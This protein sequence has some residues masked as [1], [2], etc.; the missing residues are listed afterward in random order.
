MI[1][2]R[3]AVIVGG[4]G[5]CEAVPILIRRI[6]SEMDASL[7]PAILPPFRAHEDKLRKEAELE[8]YVELA[9]R[10]LDGKGGILI[11]IDC[12]WNDS[13]PK[14]DGPALL[15]RARACR[16]DMKVTVVL[17]HR[18]FEAWFIA[19]SRSISGKRGLRADL[20]IIDDP[21]RVRGAKEWLRNRM[22]PGRPYTET[23]DQPALTQEFDMKEALRAPSFDKCYRE[24][25]W[26]LSV[27]SVE[28]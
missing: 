28:N 15:S 14:Y 9:A 22:P 25:R 11:L 17:A 4:H 6:A 7:S 24:I 23:E 5:E 8:R 20:E 27:S 19:A 3:L 18:E 10:K 21:E 12:D 26:L 16:P 1:Q 2:P 13:C